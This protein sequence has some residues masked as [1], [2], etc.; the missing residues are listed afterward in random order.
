MCRTVRTLLC[1]ASLSL[2]RCEGLYRLEPPLD[3]STWLQGPWRGDCFAVEYES[4]RESWDI[5]ETEAVQRIY[6]CRPD[7]L[8]SVRTYDRWD[9]AN[10]TLVFHEGVT[11]SFAKFRVVD[12]TGAARDCF[13]LQ[14]H[15]TVFG[16]LWVPYRRDAGE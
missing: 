7:S 16:T 12:T 6:L 14:K 8:L 5:R 3:L 11:R 4:T 2:L 15:S 9:I 13:E 10:D 1:L